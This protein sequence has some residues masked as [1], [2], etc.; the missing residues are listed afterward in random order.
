MSRRRS[1]ASSGGGLGGVLGL[2]L[3]IGVVI[4]FIW[5]ILGA[6]AL[7]G[8]FFLA[9]ALLR[10]YERRSAESAGRR[11]AIAARADQ[12]HRWVLRGDDRGIY[13]P[14][15]AELMHYL[16]PARHHLPRRHQRP[17]RAC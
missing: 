11:R 15:G 8:L 3:L 7:A 13:G 9:R 14:E 17:D 16:F 5:W 4:K 12:Q 2:L 6:V 1:T 10:W